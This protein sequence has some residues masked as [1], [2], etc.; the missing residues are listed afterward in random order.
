MIL[1]FFDLRFICQKSIKGQALTNHID[2]APLSSST[3]DP[4]DFLDNFARTY[5]FVLQLMISSN[6][7]YLT[8]QAYYH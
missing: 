2:E 3:L 7:K 1:K 5:L 8:S 6:K 4:I